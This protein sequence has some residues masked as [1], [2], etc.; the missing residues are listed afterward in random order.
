M[1]LQL[2]TH[3]VRTKSREEMMVKVLQAVLVDS[4]VFSVP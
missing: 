1:P 2:N 3:K 4:C